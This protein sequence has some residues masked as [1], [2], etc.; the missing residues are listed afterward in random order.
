MFSLA[1]KM[2][3]VGNYSEIIFGFAV[4]Y[5]VIVT[6]CLV[7]AGCSDKKEMTVVAFID[8]SGYKKLIR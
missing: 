6:E 5:R 7:S 1:A 8:F 2:C 3:I 4:F